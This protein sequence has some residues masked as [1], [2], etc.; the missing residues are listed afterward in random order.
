MKHIYSFAAAGVHEKW[1]ELGIFDKEQFVQT[2]KAVAQ[3]AKLMFKETSKRMGI[4]LV[5]GAA[6][7]SAV[8]YYLNRISNKS[9]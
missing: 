4:G 8:G 3:K 2:H 9:K 1:S 7:G 6:I 5:I